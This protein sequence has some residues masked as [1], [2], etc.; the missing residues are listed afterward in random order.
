MNMGRVP[1]EKTTA[2]PEMLSNAVM[3]AISREPTDLLHLHLHVL[4][5]AVADILEF[6]GLGVLCALVAHR[7][8]R[9]S[10]AFT[11]QREDREEVGFVQID[12]QLAIEGRPR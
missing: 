5:R 8:D 6:Q 11:L 7:A 9:P 10:M 2:F 1:K 4:D 12:M 3:N